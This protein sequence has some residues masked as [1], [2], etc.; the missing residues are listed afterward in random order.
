[1]RI[2]QQSACY[3]VHLKFAIFRRPRTLLSMALAASFASSAML[4]GWVASWL[5]TERQHVL[6][7]GVADVA[8]AAHGSFPNYTDPVVGG[9]ATTVGAAGAPCVVHLFN[10]VGLRTYDQIET[11][12]FEPPSSAK[13]APPWSSVV[14]NFSG[15][16]AGTQFDRYGALWLGG[17]ELVRRKR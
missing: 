16:I 8:P 4:L 12:E 11:A 10:R 5:G 6:A 15:D 7:A 1:M 9:P 17:V 14:L 13:C 3:L 2:L